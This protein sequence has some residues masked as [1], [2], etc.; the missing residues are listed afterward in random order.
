M[1]PTQNEFLAMLGF[2]SKIRIVIQTTEYF[3]RLPTIAGCLRMP[4]AIQ[5]YA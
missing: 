4:R 1:W 5:F 3:Q 2:S